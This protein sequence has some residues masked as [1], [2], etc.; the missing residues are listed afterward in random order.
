M[1]LLL[2][3]KVSLLHPRSMMHPF[4]IVFHLLLYLKSLVM[5]LTFANHWHYEGSS[6]MTVFH[7]QRESPVDRSV[8]KQ[9]QNPHPWPYRA[10]VLP[11]LSVYCSL[12]ISSGAKP[13]GVHSWSAITSRVPSAGLP[14]CFRG[15]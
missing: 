7:P 6:V 4:K 8:E 11:S 10:S 3:K 5:T 1:L 13:A 15:H 12:I 9:T 2:A 14:L